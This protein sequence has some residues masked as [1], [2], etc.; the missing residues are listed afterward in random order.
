MYD[1]SET[2]DLQDMDY[3]E[4]MNINLNDFKNKSPR[5]KKTNN[6]NNIKN[7]CNDN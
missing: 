5:N 2:N 6:K 4:K 1:F 3:G 7:N